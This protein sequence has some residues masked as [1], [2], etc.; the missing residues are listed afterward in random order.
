MQNFDKND[1]L[2]LV[3]IINEN[4]RAWK[5]WPQLITHTLWPILDSDGD[6]SGAMS[7]PERQMEQI[8]AMI[9]T[10]QS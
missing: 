7:R 8:V 4:L 10:N 9:N 2:I 3:F 6:D 1:E 5:V